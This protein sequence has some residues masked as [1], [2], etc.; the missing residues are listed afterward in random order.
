MTFGAAAF[1]DDLS[2]DGTAP[3]CPQAADVGLGAILPV[4]GADELDATDMAVIE[5]VERETRQPGRRAAWPAVRHTAALPGPVRELLAPRPGW[6]AEAW[7]R[8]LADLAR[9]TVDVRRSAQLRL[10]ADVLKAGSE[11]H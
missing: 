9:V 10:A 7:A 8:R 6:T 11:A 1:L 5:A 3:D 2:T 4:K